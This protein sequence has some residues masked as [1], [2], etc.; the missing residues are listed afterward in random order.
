MT[1][2]TEGATR[3]P[4][5]APSAAPAAAESAGENHCVPQPAQRPAA[6]AEC[7]Q[8]DRCAQAWAMPHRS[9]LTRGGL[10]LASSAA[11]LLP[12]LA[13][14]LAGALA[15]SDAQESFSPRQAL[16]TAGGFVLGSVFA[17]LLV[18]WIKRRCHEPA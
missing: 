6:C 9:S 1:E 17:W 12:P 13:A 2:P 11:F 16:A 7:A 8:A 5:G 15:G 4:A 18:R 14:V 10:A 3:P